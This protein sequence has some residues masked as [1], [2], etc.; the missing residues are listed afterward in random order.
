[1]QNKISDEQK[2]HDLAVAYATYVSARRS[3][4]TDVDS[5]YQEYE[6]ALE[7]FNFLVKRYG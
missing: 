3:E 2:A 1:M 7:A 5:F 4:K 6:S